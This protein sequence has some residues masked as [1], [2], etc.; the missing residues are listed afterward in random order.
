MALDEWTLSTGSQVPAE[1]WH[2]EA[3]RLRNLMDVID[4]HVTEAYE[5]PVSW[6][7]E[8]MTAEQWADPDAIEAEMV[9]NRR[10]DAFGKLFEAAGT[11]GIAQGRLNDMPKNI[12]HSRWTAGVLHR[13]SFTASFGFYTRYPVAQGGARPLEEHPPVWLVSLVSDVVQ[14][15]DAPT[16][17]IGNNLLRD[18]L[19]DVRDAVEAWTVTY[20]PRNVD[21][22]GLPETLTVYPCT[23]PAGGHVVVADLELAAH[24]PERLVADLLLLDDRIR[25]R[26]P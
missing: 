25:A 19:M 26:T 15:I 10:V 22:T 7:S 8:G 6:H 21:A 11:S 16:V 2:G 1:R 18:E 20:L 4:A 5:A 14:A 23:A 17:R 3:R 24:T 13:W 12:I 9:G